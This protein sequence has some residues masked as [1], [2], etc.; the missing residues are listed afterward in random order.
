MKTIAEELKKDMRAKGIDINLTLALLDDF[1]NGLY[2]NLEPVKAVSVP[3]IDGT[4]VIDMRLFAH[5]KDGVYRIDRDS[6]QK[7]LDNAGIPFP[8]ALKFEKTSDGKEILVFS[9]EAL[10]DIGYQL[11]PKT[12]FGVLNG[13]SATS[14]ADIKKNKALGEQVF[15][16]LEA[17]F[18]K[19]APLCKEVPKGIT[20]AYINPDGSPGFSF[21]AL[22]MRSR[23]MLAKR[24]KQR[25]G[26]MPKSS[27][28][29]LEF[30]PLFQMSS[31]VNDEQLKAHYAQAQYEPILTELA[32]ETGLAAARW[33]TGIQ[34][35]IAAYSHSSL[36]RPKTIFDTA[37][38]R[39]N[40]A[41]PLPG[42][43]GQVFRILAPVLK[44]FHAQGIRFAC[45]GNVDNI[46]YMPDPIELAILLLSGKSAA[47]DFSFRTKLDVKGGILVET[48][49]GNRTI[50]D[51]GPA[52]SAEE[53]SRLE[54]EGYSI[55]FNCA[56]GIFDLDYLVPKIDELARKLPVRF[57]D[58]DKDAGKYSQ[59]EQVTWEITSLL[60]SF[61]AFAVDKR[62]RFLAAKLLAENLLTSGIGL[63]A[64]DM[65]EIIRT[66]SRTLNAGLHRLLTERY[67]LKL[68]NGKYQPAELLD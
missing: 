62:E 9:Y 63:D 68:K 5:D 1:N 34:P 23:L 12:A 25:T 11:L 28:P 64:S 42:G 67:G 3:R 15:S 7:A 53:V 20:P 40:S 27:N 48:V 49:S 54:S 41:F 36:G 46:G 33:H 45:L 56:S 38:G 19:L 59:A 31:S 61:L 43:H 22:K 24:S 39:P 30:L 17:E 16:I 13:G 14:Y 2:D 51:I 60:P 57:S 37:W 18:Q 32:K 55:L 52:I 44:A 29:E 10:L 21:L 65:P 47:F 58:Q 50:A 8:Q 35:M 6:A 66:T 26:T 4:S